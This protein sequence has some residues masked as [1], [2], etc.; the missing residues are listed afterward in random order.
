M[1]K[2]SL[3]IPIYNGEK[4]L[5][6][7]I[8]SILCQTF[9]DFEIIFVND[10]TPDNS[11]EII[12]EY[13]QNDNRIKII[14]NLWNKGQ[15]ASRNEGIKHATGEYLM[16]QDQDDWFEPTAFEEAYNQ[17]T[18]NNNDY[19]IFL[20]NNYYPEVNTYEL[21]NTRILPFEPVINEPDIKPWA[22]KG[23][24]I[25]STFAW[26]QIYRTDFIKKN[27]IQFSKQRNGEDT[28]FC[29]KA[30]AYAESISIINK[31]LY[32]YRVYN[33]QTT[34]RLRQKYKELFK[35]REE[36]YKALL[37]SP[38]K[39]DMMESF[40]IY[41][42]RSIWYWYKRNARDDKTIRHG[43]CKMMRKV[44]RMLYKKYDI[45][46]IK[47]YINYENFLDVAKIAKKQK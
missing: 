24:S 33:E 14:K 3:I 5:R 10:C 22:I 26:C 44:Y 40:L 28:P 15:G 43:Y 4:Y 17:I 21:A 19:V 30:R 8:D 41:Y 12:K 31:P 23:K 38:H 27:K 34:S 16:F 25:I 45:E 32:N 39:D 1:P 9:Q 35:V 7:C 42:I 36:A 18:K 29:I 11:I 47:D 6:Q 13:A 37:K 46:A 20:F 2:I